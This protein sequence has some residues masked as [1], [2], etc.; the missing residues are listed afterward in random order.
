VGAGPEEPRLRALAGGRPSVRFAG[1]VG[2]ADL[3]AHY[4]AADLFCLPSVTIAEAFGIVLLEAMACGRPLVTTSLP[5]GISA[6]NRDGQTGLIV[7]PGDVPALGEAIG[8]LAG[9]RARR[10]AMGR[11]ARRVFEAEYTA[12]RMVE[13]Y[14]ELYREALG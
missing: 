6:V 13:R 7:P 11:A 1:R 3:V 8:A 10:E 5:T 14:L 12:E 4:H 2:D 9:D